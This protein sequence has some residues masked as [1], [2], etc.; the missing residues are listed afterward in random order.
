[1][2]PGIVIVKQDDGDR[3]DVNNYDNDDDVPIGDSVDD[4]IEAFSTLGINNFVRRYP[5][6]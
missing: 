6:A 2:V 5:K 4:G 1:M 3:D